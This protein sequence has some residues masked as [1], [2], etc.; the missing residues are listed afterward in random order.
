L[1]SDWTPYRAG[2]RRYWDLYGGPK[3]LLRSPFLQ[4]ALFLTVVAYPFKGADT[5]PTDLA[6]SALPN[7][8]GFSVGALAIVLALSSAPVFRTLAGKGRERSYFMVLTTSLVHFIFVQVVAL[9]VG[10]FGKITDTPFLEPVALFLLFYAILVVVPAGL[11]LFQTAR[12]YNT[13]ASV[14]E[15]R[16]PDGPL[17]YPRAPA[18]PYRSLRGAR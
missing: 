9:T 15:K 14:P 18:K 2:L 8:L 7:L 6:V 5:K 3:A 12:I 16:G 13:A 4:I 10:I 17:G 1:F 11:H